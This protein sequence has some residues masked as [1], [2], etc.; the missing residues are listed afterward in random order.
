MAYL[1]NNECSNILRDMYAQSTGS[2]TY[3]NDKDIIGTGSAENP[4]YPAGSNVP[5]STL[6]LQ[7]I[8]DVGNDNSIWGTTEQFTKSLVNRL[9]KRFFLQRTAENLYNSPFIVDNDEFSSL[10]SVVS[11]E[12][13][14]VTEASNWK[15]FENGDLVGQYQIQLPK[16]SETLYGKQISFAIPISIS[17]E[18]YQSLGNASEI[19]QLINMI[20][21]TLYNRENEY[22]SDL[23][24]ANRNNL[25]A[26]VMNY[27][28]SVGAKGIH[29]IDL[30]K[31][32][33]EENGIE[34]QTAEEYLNN[35][36]AVRHGASIFNEFADYIR[37]QSTA[38]SIADKVGFI[39]NDRFVFQ[40]LRK[41]K[42][43]L[44]REVLS[45]SFARSFADIG[46]RFDIVPFWQRTTDGTTTYDF[47]T[48]SSIDIKSSSDGTVSQY[49]GIVGLMCDKYSAPS[50]IIKHRV[51]HQRFDI[52]NLDHYEVQN[53]MKYANILDLPCLVFVINDY[54]TE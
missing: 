42:T 44:D 10:M 49:K 27:A 18:Q 4:Q 6:D 48:L 34:A 3:V 28:S 21:T 11:V 43:S 1:N 47:D 15:V 51:G 23:D 54:E 22:L 46:E 13:P 50:G 31:V 24:M 41:F 14:E 7:G 19:V 26:E 16:I 39:P 45:D 20:W 17:S 29:V 37:K 32:Y 33:C 53:H 25:I 40:L 5:I 36:K 9:T 35:G 12:S 52:E 30:N 8:V 2:D 38:F